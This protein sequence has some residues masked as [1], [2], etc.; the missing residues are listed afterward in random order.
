MPIYLESLRCISQRLLS[1]HCRIGSLEIDHRPVVPGSSILTTAQSTL[2]MLFCIYPLLDRS[3]TSLK[4]P[5]TIQKKH[6]IHSLTWRT[7]NLAKFDNEE[8]CMH[9][10]GQ[11]KN[12]TQQYQTQTP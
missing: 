3:P 10:R 2:E 11:F 5:Q 9:T 4:N 8:L 12:V 6:P 7:S 1:S